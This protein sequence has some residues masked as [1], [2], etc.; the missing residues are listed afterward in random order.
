MLYIYYLILIL[1]WTL[2]S[3]YYYSHRCRNWST[4]WLGNLITFAWLVVVVQDLN[5][6]I[7]TPELIQLEIQRWELKKQRNNMIIIMGSNNGLIFIENAHCARH[8]A[9][10]FPCKLSVNPKNPLWAKIPSRFYKWGNRLNEVGLFAQGLPATQCIKHMLLTSLLSGSVAGS[11]A[12]AAC[13]RP[14]RIWI[15][16]NEFVWDSR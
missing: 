5:V 15:V 12:Q 9:K 8:G 4:W 11:S 7:L 13:W 6:R 10:H 14:S 2:C 1:K 3:K 16:D